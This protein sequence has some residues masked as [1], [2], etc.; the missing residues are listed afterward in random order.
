MAIDKRIETK[1]GMEMQMQTNH[2]SHFALT[3]RLLDLLEKS[4]SGGRIVNISSGLHRSAKD[5]IT[6]DDLDRTK[7]YKKWQVYGESKL[8]NLLF[9]AELNTRLQKSGSKV[10]STAAHPGVSSTNLLKFSNSLLQSIVNFV[11]GLLVQS[12]YMGCLPTVYAAVNPSVKA[13]DYV[14]PGNRGEKSG[15]P[16]LVGRSGPARDENLQRKL[17][18]VSLEK[19]GVTCSL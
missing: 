11:G 10:T 12:P 5:G 7:E 19:T 6:F 18:E 8:C 3:I 15:Y 4:T 9:T 14:G 17:W 1:D 16:K 13:G 2:F